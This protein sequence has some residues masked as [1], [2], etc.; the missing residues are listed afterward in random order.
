MKLFHLF[1]VTLFHMKNFL[2]AVSRLGVLQFAT[3]SE[4]GNLSATHGHGGT[5]AETP[6]KLFLGKTFGVL[7]LNAWLSC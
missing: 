2:F 7:C 6:C 5:C 3:V 1:P 4:W